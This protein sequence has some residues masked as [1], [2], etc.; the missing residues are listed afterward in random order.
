[1][2]L[3]NLMKSWMFSSIK[4]WPVQDSLHQQ[5]SDLDLDNV[6][7][8]G[9]AD[10][11]YKSLQGLQNTEK[12]NTFHHHKSV[13][14][15]QK[16]ARGSNNWLW[17]VQTLTAMPENASLSCNRQGS[18]QEMAVLRGLEANS[19]IAATHTYRKYR[20][21]RWPTYH[22]LPLQSKHST[23]AIA[24]CTG[25]SSKVVMGTSRNACAKR[26]QEVPQ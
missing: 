11:T 1:M 7:C 4:Y 9:A 17:P 16:E 26:R 15:V 13:A 6:F 3:W 18:N 23:L 21:L 8:R 14:R 19:P 12:S 22:P 20:Y 25:S 10:Q 2:R 5:P 24:T